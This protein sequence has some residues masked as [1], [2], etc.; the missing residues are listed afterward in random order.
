M[1]R[2]LLLAA[3]LV[4]AVAPAPA[5]QEP[6]AAV[7]FA[8]E[9]PRDL[10]WAAYLAGE[11]RSSEYVPAL[12]ALLGAEGDD[13]YYVQAAALDAL[14]QLGATAPSGVL[15]AL[16]GE[17]P[18]QTIILLVRDPE[19]HREALLAHAAAATYDAEW[20]AVCNALVAIRADGIAESLLR[21]LTVRARVVV[22]SDDNVG[23]NVGPGGG[24]GIGCGWGM[25]VPQGFPPHASYRLTRSPRPGAVLL[26]SG[27]VAVYYTREVTPAGETFDGSRSSTFEDR[28]A[29]RVEY[30]R[31][32]L[33][34]AGYELELDAHPS[35]TVVWRDDAALAE[36]VERVEAELKRTLRAVAK[37][38]GVQ[39]DARVEVTIEDHR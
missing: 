23:W 2:C 16:H 36:E 8:S 24:F 35:F 17:F 34:S 37:R 39:A 20:L 15:A 4:A 26:A 9:D 30:L 6:D 7:L 33:G 28:D 11:R 31:E 14:V 5:R 22:V 21:D 12:V 10:A 18:D 19:A 1:R 29:R 38:L 3:C 25:R 32:L 13:A 27:P